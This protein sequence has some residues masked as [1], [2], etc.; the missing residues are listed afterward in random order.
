MET[1]ALKMASSQGFFAFLFVCLLF[2]VLKENARRESQYQKT[3]DT[4][5]QKFDIVDKIE[6]DVVEIKT[7]VM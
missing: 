1:E 5:A 6:K 4:L 3:I 7:H 2:Y